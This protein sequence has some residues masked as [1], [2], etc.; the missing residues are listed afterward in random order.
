MLKYFDH[1]KEK[2]KTAFEVFQINVVEAR[3][4]SSTQKV[5]GHFGAKTDLGGPTENCF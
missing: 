1:F 5:E 4:D 2:H 3:G